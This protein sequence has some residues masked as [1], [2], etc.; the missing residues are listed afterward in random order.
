[1]IPNK[2]AQIGRNWKSHRTSSNAQA[3][4]ERCLA[5]DYSMANPGLRPAQDRSARRSQL[6]PYGNEPNTSQQHSTDMSP[7]WLNGTA[8]TD[9]QDRVADLGLIAW[10]AGRWCQGVITINQKLQF[11][12]SVMQAR[13]TF[14]PLRQGHGSFRSPTSEPRQLRQ[15]ADRGPSLARARC[16]PDGDPPAHPRE[17]LTRRADRGHHTL[18][19]RP[20]GSLTTGCAS[21]GPYRPPGPPTPS[22]RSKSTRTSP[23]IGP[24]LKGVAL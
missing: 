10:Q 19:Y 5:D 16:Q 22:S 6:L 14:L 4:L 7:R 21:R 23:E 13:V 9:W 11:L 1:M 18:D 20:Q 12:S 17:D 3:F 2:S 15:M 8:P 24:S